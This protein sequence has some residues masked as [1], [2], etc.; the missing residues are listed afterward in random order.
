MHKPDG[1]KDE[2]LL[3]KETLQSFGIGID[4]D[5]MMDQVVVRIRE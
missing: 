5:D 1:G 4:V 3:G 2:L